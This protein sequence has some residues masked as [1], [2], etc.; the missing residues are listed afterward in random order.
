MHRLSIRHSRA[1]NAQAVAMRDWLHDVAWDS[2]FLDLDP[3]E[4]RR[5]V[6][7]ALV[8]GHTMFWVRMPA[9]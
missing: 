1:S 5:I 4:A 7:L 9:L 6:Q 8:C 2:V 3:T